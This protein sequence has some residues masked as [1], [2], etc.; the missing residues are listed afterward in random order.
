MAADNKLLRLPRELPDPLL[1][2]SLTILS[3]CNRLF[4]LQQPMLDLRRMV[5]ESSE[6]HLHAKSLFEGLLIGL[7]REYLSS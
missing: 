5:K 3:C 4:S 1:I 6:G 2:N 7:L